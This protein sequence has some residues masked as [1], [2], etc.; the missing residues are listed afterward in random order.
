MNDND[1][2]IRDKDKN[3]IALCAGMSQQERDDFIREHISEGA[4]YS[5]LG[6]IKHE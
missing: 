1:P 2:V 4:H 6:E 3:I 5:T